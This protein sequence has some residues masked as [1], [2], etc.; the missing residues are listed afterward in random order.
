MKEKERIGRSK[1]KPE[2]MHYDELIKKHPSEIWEYVV[3]NRGLIGRLYD[4]DEFI[5]IIE[6]VAPIVINGYEV[7]EQLLL[8]NNQ[9]DKNHT[10]TTN[11]R[12]IVSA[13]ASLN[14]LAGCFPSVTELAAKTGLSRVT[15]TE[16]LKDL[17]HGKIA[18][19]YNAKYQCLR[20]SVLMSVF[21][22]AA[23]AE[24]ENLRLKAKKM[25]LDQTASPKSSSSNI[26]LININNTRITAQMI[27]ELPKEFQQKIAD[28]IVAA[29]NPAANWWEFIAIDD[30]PEPDK[31]IPPP[32]RSEVEA[33]EYGRNLNFS[34]FT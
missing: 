25:F 22:D 21:N 15:V 26:T 8:T 17:K 4:E 16:H 28:I 24:N 7:N 20:E 13:M 10:W 6:Q 11:H 19:M 23:F 29:K 18:D 33:K 34:D 27:T 5:A 14:R 32:L 2:I 1:K 3:K 12:K 9:D 31:L 30:E